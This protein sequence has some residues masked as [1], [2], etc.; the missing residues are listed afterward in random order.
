MRAQ[1][2]LRFGSCRARLCG[3]LRL[4]AFPRSGGANDGNRGRLDGV[5][6]LSRARPYRGG[7]ISLDVSMPRLIIVATSWRCIS[8]SSCANIVQPRRAE[9]L[10]GGSVMVRRPVPPA[11]ESARAARH[12]PAV[13]IVRDRPLDRRL[14]PFARPVGSGGRSS[15]R[16]DRLVAMPYLIVVQACFHRAPLGGIYLIGVHGQAR[17]RAAARTPPDLAA[18]GRVGDPRRYAQGHS[19]AAPYKSCYSAAARIQLDRTL[20]AIN[21]SFPSGHAAT[22][23]GAW[24]PRV[25]LWPQPVAVLC[26]RRRLIAASRGVMGAHYRSEFIMGGLIGR[27]GDAC[28]GGR[29]WPTD[30]CRFAAP[31]SDSRSVCRRPEAPL[32]RPGGRL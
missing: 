24:R 27:A 29:I 3:E 1:M 6:A 7:G 25:V 28:A 15:D 26:R 22:G 32:L 12:R 5:R 30:G 21:G 13:E 14:R 17:M 9:R 2:R 4:A 31:A 11:P 19:R 8:G 20:N 18:F 10:S 23:R 16:L